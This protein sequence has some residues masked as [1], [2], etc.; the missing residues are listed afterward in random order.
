[1]SRYIFSRAL[2]WCCGM[3]AVIVMIGVPSC[4]VIL[5]AFMQSVRLDGV[6]MGLVSLYTSLLVASIVPAD[7]LN[8]SGSSFGGVC[9][10]L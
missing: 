6:C 8:V 3:Y 4:G 10:S 9:V 1:M 2:V 5:V 7:L